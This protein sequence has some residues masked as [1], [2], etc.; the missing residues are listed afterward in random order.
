MRNDVGMLIRYLFTSATTD[1]LDIGA[2][3]KT[4]ANEARRSAAFCPIAETGKY[5]IR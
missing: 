4:L 3:M 5:D 1:I 2:R